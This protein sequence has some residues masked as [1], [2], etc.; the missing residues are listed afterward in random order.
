MST[1]KAPPHAELK[2]RFFA[3]Y[4]PILGID[5]N[6]WRLTEAT[7]SEYVVRNT[8]TD[9]EIGI[10]RSYI[11]PLSE[12][13][14]PTMIVGLTKQLEYRAGSVWPVDRKVLELPSKKIPVP[15]RAEGVTEP[16][17]PRGLS[18]ILGT[19]GSGT[20]STAG[21]LIGWSMGIL[22]VV[23]FGV[24]A[25]VKFTPD[26]KPTFVAKDQNYLE[27]NRDDDYFA[28]VR[29]LGKPASEHERGGE[30]ELYYKALYYPDRK[31]AVILMAPKGEEAHYIGAMGTGDDGKKW[32]L[33]H[34][35]EFAR[36]A[37][38]SAMLRALPKF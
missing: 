19:G 33:L 1:P 24:Y 30:G 26:A 13:D 20:D 29:K 27:L 4:P 15:M 21:K 22:I 34:S 23:L 31:Y 6:E 28:V 36:G 14:H 2:D 11:G 8:K 37:N 3:F 32:Q 35:V 5:H 12:V 7:W 38:T 9:Q 18:A 25:L 17:A 10:P 16:A